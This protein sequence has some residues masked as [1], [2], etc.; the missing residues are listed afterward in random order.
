MNATTP[1]GRIVTVDVTNAL[2][3]KL[4]ARAWD[5]WED[6]TTTGK[7]MNVPLGTHHVDMD[8]VDRELQEAPGDESPLTAL[9]GM[10]IYTGD[11]ATTNLRP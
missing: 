7:I 1:T 4:V 9:V 3:A 2:K 10:M 11:L 5:E 6:D 8:T